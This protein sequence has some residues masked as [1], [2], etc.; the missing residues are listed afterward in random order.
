MAASL[1]ADDAVRRV[2]RS[3]A[4]LCGGTQLRQ[5]DAL[6]ALRGDDPVNIGCP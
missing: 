5:V 2:L 4:N 1:S 6:A 3:S